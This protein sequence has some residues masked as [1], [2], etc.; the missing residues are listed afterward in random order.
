MERFNHF[1]QR[2]GKRDNT[3]LYCNIV[4]DKNE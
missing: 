2:P 4:K 1:I 3:E